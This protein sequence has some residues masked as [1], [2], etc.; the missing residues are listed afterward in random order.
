VTEGP[1][2]TPPGPAAEIHVWR[3]YLDSDG[4]PVEDGLPAAERERAARIAQPRRRRRW[5]SSRWALRET[6]A[7]YLDPE[8][9]AIELVTAIGGKPALADMSALRFNLSHSRD[10][11]LVAVTLRRD[12]GIDVE[13]IGKRSRAFYDEWVRREAIG[14]CFG[15]GLAEPPPAQPVRVAP[16][17][18]GAEWAAALAVASTVELP[19]RRFELR[20]A[21]TRAAPARR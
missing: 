1:D 18:F 14:K 13:W 5:T 15:G 17:E 8:P 7:R 21:P 11:A 4:W 2:R 16:L 9:A 12:V 19:V 10:L 6:L 20:P 3:A